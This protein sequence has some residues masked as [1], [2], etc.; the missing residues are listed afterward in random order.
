[1]K[2]RDMVKVGSGWSKQI[3]EVVDLSWVAASEDYMPACS[4]SNTKEEAV[5]KA[6]KWL[7]EFPS[8][9]CAVVAHVDAGQ[10]VRIMFGKD[11][12]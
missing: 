8:A 5:I 11:V 3:F 4:P 7:K 2:S 12:P 9:K 6:E 10:I 1:M